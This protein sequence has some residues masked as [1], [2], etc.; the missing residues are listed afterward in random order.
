MGAQLNVEIP[1]EVSPIAMSAASS[2]GGMTFRT[3]IPADVITMFAGF[4]EAAQ[5]MQGG[6]FEGQEEEPQF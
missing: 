4:A 1:D 3:V 5:A 6:G 2:S